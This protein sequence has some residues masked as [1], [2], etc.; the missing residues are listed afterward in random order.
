M[1]EVDIFSILPL[2]CALFVFFFGLFILAKQP[3]SHIHQLLAAF[4]A[5]MFFWMFGT[6][7]MF[8]LRGS[9]AGAAVFWDR[10]VYIGV[11]FMPPLMHHFS[12]IFTKRKKQRKILYLNYLFALVFLFA[13]RTPYFV[14][15]LYVY[16][17][18]AHTQAKVL[19]HIF[20]AYFFLG[21]GVFFFNMFKY[22]RSAQ[23][24]ES[25][26]QALYVFLAFAVVIFIGGSAYLYAYGID[27][28]FPFAYVSGVIFPVMLFYAATRYHL[29]GT[30]VIATE[31]IVG[32]AIFAL[33]TEMFLSSS[34]V[35]LLLRGIITLIIAVIGYLL[36]QSVR[37][38]I[39]RREQITLLAHS[40]EKANGRLQELDR[41]KTEFLS[42][43]SHQLRTP[44]SVIK[45]YIELI[46][47]GAYGKAPRKM[48][49][50][51]GEM[52][53]SN[54]RL[55]K[56][57]DNFLNIS[58]IEQGRTKYAFG[59][60]DMNALIDSVVLELAE[61]ARGKGLKLKWRRRPGVKHIY[62]DDEKI[63][64]VVFNFVDNAIKYSDKGVVTVSLQKE[65][66]GVALRVVDEGLGFNKEDENNFF[67]KFYRGKNVEG[68]NVNGTGLGIYVCR[69]FAE[70]HGGHVWAHSDGIGKGSEFGFW[71]PDHRTKVH[72]KKE[73]EGKK[74]KQMIVNQYDQ[75]RLIK[76]HLRKKL[77]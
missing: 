13:S 25:K 51:L 8:G 35:E 76:E 33:V 59:D 70:A 3:R 38:E 64:H 20:L 77:A 4:C 32:I 45:G 47:D 65:R 66:N 1:F 6:F 30:K 48:K 27:T 26:L 2:S 43:A 24:Q 67:N 22:Y 21:T 10:F 5:S 9:N 57:I 19:H 41:Q 75:E 60:H 53:Q 16:W 50:V 55:V 68:T 46:E 28:K 74:V 12:L 15:D 71:I 14:D 63:R 31:V 61:R 42:I 7:M 69:Q 49:K 40:L 52:D 73:R 54:E 36:I 11:V 44:L 18:G 58:R 72:E 56:L 37:Q 34:T 23:K 29:L 39:E 17:W 62:M